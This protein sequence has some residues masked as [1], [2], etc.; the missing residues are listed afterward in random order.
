M[1]FRNITPEE[2]DRLIKNKNKIFDLT[3]DIPEITNKYKNNKN[4][5]DEINYDNEQKKKFQKYDEI[6]DK[7]LSKHIF[8][9]SKKHYD[10]DTTIKDYDEDTTIKD[11]DNILNYFYDQKYKFNTD[12]DINNSFKNIFEEYDL[13]YKPKYISNN[14]EILNIMKKLKRSNIPNELYDFL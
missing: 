5:L 4:I 13:R 6:L 8:N 7:S 10:E 2:Y 14:I 1:S 11:L 9:K 3:H 12:E